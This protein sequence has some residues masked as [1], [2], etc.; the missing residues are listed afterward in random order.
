LANRLHRTDEAIA[1]GRRALQT[2]PHLPLTFWRL[3]TWLRREERHAELAALQAA[4]IE[5]AADSKTRAALTLSLARL[6]AGPLQA[7]DQAVDTLL[8]A[9]KLGQTRCAAIELCDLYE[10]LERYADLVELLLAEANDTTDGREAMAWRLRAAAILDEHLGETLR[11]LELHQEILAA[12]PENAVATP[13]AGRIYHRLGRW[14]ELVELHRQELETDPGRPDAPALWC[15]VGRLYDE[16]LGHP[17]DAI[18]AYTAALRIDPS[19]TVA[20]DALERLLRAER[21][22]EELADVLAQHADARREPHAAADALCGA[23]EVADARLGDLRTALG[24]YEKA[25]GRGAAFSPAAYGLLRAQLRQEMFAE[26]AATLARMIDSAATPLERCHLE[27]ELL[28]LSEHR[29][30]Q[31][32]EPALYDAVARSSPYGSRLRAEQL[33][34][35]RLRH[36]ADFPEFLSIIGLQTLDSTLAAA[37]LLESSYLHEF[38][39]AVDNQVYAAQQAFARCPDDPAVLRSVQRATRAACRW[40][41]LAALHTEE[42]Q[43][44]TDPAMRLC[45]L[46][47]ALAAHLRSGQLQLAA[48]LARRCLTID[49]HHLPSL[50]LLSQLAATAQSWTELAAWQDQLAESCANPANRLQACLRAAEAWEHGVGNISQ[51]LSSVNRA[52]ADDACQTEAFDVAAR[53]LRTTG[54]HFQLSQLYERRIRACSDS[55]EK[56][57]LLHLQARLLRDKVKDAARAIVALSDLLALAPDHEGALSDLAELLCAERRWADAATTLARLGQGASDPGTRRQ[58]RAR[59]ATIWLDSLHSPAR[60]RQV[61]QQAL[62]EA[63]GELSLKQLMVRIAFAEG[64]WNEV[65]RLIDEIAAEDQPALQAWA[66]VELAEV[67]RVGLRDESLREHS[68]HEALT[69]AAR[70]P[71]TIEALVAKYR[72]RGL[73]P[74][75]VDVGRRVAKQ[76]DDP[77]GATPLR[78]AL[79]QVLLKDVGQPGEALAEVRDVLALDSDSPAARLLLAESLERQ[80]EVDSAVESYRHTLDLDALSVDAYRGLDRLLKVLGHPRLARAAAS[81]VGWLGGGSSPGGLSGTGE[82][83]SRPSANL[84]FAILPGDPQLRPMRDLLALLVPHLGAVYPLV[85]DHPVASTHPLALAARPLALSLGLSGVMVSVE[86]DLPAMAGVGDPVPLCIAPRLASTPGSAAFRFWAARA[87]AS[88]VT[89]ASLLERL[90]DAELRGLLDALFNARPEEHAQQQRRKQLQRA[91][92]RKVRKEIE[93]ISVPRMTA[94]AWARLRVEETCRADM[95]GLLFAEDAKACLSELAAVAG[96][97]R[98]GQGSPRIPNLLRFAVS[99]LHEA[100]ARQLWGTR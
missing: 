11:A 35:R 51:A 31:L 88:A 4:Y 98:G 23:A 72:E 78:L 89:A 66:M 19:C 2:A 12:D 61:L 38:G 37:Y 46:G 8:T 26:A 34:V 81:I 29:L 41:D 67:A 15:R 68:E 43:R 63:P 83:A 57:E 58:A 45:A 44:E 28:R 27:L 60:A 24:L 64:Q 92:P 77:K 69:L 16:N 9:R 95:V 17:A 3:R 65:R 82:D 6:Q 10:R 71:E 42:A 20:L 96:G 79:A 70:Y 100:C 47:Q 97:D 30:G 76:L 33:R 25:V 73:L 74:R 39:G 13:A 18:E 22:F 32:P 36:T 53:L 59:E 62:D 49:R 93:Q 52:L 21:R 1:A 87:L 91:L 7:V 80:G 86:G 85:Q 94:A 56:T 84:D 50:H 40:P 48:D 90:S 54:D 99:E 5:R 55:A 14:R 75:L